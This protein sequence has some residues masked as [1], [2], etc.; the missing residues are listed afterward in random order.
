MI[1]CGLRGWVRPAEI[2]NQKIVHCNIAVRE[3]FRRANGGRK[4]TTD[5]DFK[6]LTKTKA[7]LAVALVLGTASVALANDDDERG[8]NV[9]PG[10]TDGVN[11][12]YHPGLF[13]QVAPQGYA[14]Q[15]YGFAPAPKQT[16]RHV[17]TTQDR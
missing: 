2:Q 15:A 14:G 13:R 8:G 17:R 11:P 9:L 4:K 7:L 12:A 5:G 1:R 10:S 16:H 3:Y 6:M